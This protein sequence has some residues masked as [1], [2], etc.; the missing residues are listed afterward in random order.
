VG[1]A[2]TKAYT[3]QVGP[4]GVATTKAYTSQV[5]PVGPKQHTVHAWLLPQSMALLLVIIQS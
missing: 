2:S 1:V 3:S 4:V 5:G